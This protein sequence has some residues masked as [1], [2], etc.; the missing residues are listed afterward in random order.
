MESP[1]LKI[2]GNSQL[3]WMAAVVGFGMERQMW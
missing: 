3:G 1:A 2:G